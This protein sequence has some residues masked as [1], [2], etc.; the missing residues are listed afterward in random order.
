MYRS[1]KRKNEA[2]ITMLQP[3]TRSSSSSS[4]SFP[5]LGLL[6]S[7]TGVTKLNRSIFLKVCLNFFSLLVGIL[8]TFLGSCQSSSCQQDL[9]VKFI[10]TTERRP[11]KYVGKRKEK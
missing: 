5:V 4:S 3:G 9:T 2:K 1:L 11:I 10:M 7:V 6:R 8:E